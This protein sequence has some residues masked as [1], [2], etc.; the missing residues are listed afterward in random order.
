MRDPRFSPSTRPR[1]SPL[2]GHLTHAHASSRAPPML[3]GCE[4]CISSRTVRRY[5]AIFK[6]IDRVFNI[7]RPRKILYMAIDGVAPRAKVHRPSPP[8]RKA[9]RGLHATS[10]HSTLQ[11]VALCCFFYAPVFCR[12]MC[13]PIA[14]SFSVSPPS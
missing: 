14:A 12:D 5:L 10:C 6:Y 2:H 7:I 4:Q 1:P 3:R 8:L 13:P 9:D 11:L